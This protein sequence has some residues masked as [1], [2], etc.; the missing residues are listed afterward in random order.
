[1]RYDTNKN[2]IMTKQEFLQYKE[3]QRK[4]AAYER[5]KKLAGLGECKGLTDDEWDDIETPGKSRFKN[6]LTKQS[7]F[8]K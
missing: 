6:S 2:T 8:K 1:M 3:E 5:I 7:S 4:Q